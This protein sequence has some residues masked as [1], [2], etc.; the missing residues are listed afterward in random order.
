MDNVML[1]SALRAVLKAKDLSTALG[2]ITDLL[3]AVSRDTATG[4][5]AEARRAASHRAGRPAGELPGED[6]KHMD[7]IF[8]SHH[9]PEAPI[10][11]SRSGGVIAS[12][13]YR[14]GVKPMVQIKKEA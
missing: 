5:P 13:L 7:R 6:A 11:A 12:H 8:A 2:L 9:T 10:V 4:D 3:A 1:E 14:P